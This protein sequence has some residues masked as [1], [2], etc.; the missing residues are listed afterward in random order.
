M[1]NPLKVAIPYMLILLFLVA[2]VLPL[3]VVEALCKLQ[4]E[5]I[6]QGLILRVPIQALVAGIAVTLCYYSTFHDTEVWNGYVTK[7]FQDTVSCEH[8][9][10]CNCR[11]TCSG[12]GKD[13]RCSETCDTC[14]E[15][16]HDYDWVVQTSNNE[17]VVIS[18]VDR[19]GTTEPARFTS[20]KS[21]E[22]TAIEHSYI[23]YTLADS[24]TLLRRRGIAEKYK[25]SFPTYPQV[26]DYYRL[27]R[28]HGPYT[29]TWQG[30]LDELNKAVGAAKQ[31]NVM[32]VVSPIPHREWF[33]G[34]QEH[35]LGGKKND[36][37]IVVF[38]TNEGIIEWAE[39]MAWTDRKDFVVSL[40]SELEGL[41][42]L[43]AN[44]VP[45]I[46]DNV[47]MRFARKP[48][49]DYKYLEENI[50]PSGFQWFL[51]LLGSL[52]AAGIAYAVFKAYQDRS[53]F[54]R[55]IY[56]RP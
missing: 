20:V 9:Y 2:T 34:L 18:R 48:M 46:R 7:K 30:E 21:G 1:A 5:Q 11:Q 37:V 4:K 10:N 32:L 39:V 44:V 50:S 55:S 49:A 15:H 36:V 56:G 17:K 42:F 54:R 16:S 31:A 13:Q 47:N 35:W 28:Y 14:Y 45:V 25:G 19:Q 23:N 38:V 24:D 22:P 43:P 40:S 6:F 51:T 33:Y 8:S 27:R 29:S 41:K 53:S 52:I 3:L 26:Q 12:S